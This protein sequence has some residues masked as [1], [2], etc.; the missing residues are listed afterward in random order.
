MPRSDS[1]SVIPLPTL[2]RI[3][4]YAGLI[5]FVIP[6]WLLLDQ[7]W[8]GLELQGAVPFGIYAPYIFISYS[9]V[10]L[11][12][13]SGT[14]WAS[15]QMVDNKNLAKFAVL[16][17]N[18][19]ALNA[20]CALLLIYIAPIMAAYSVTFLMFG[21]ISLLWVEHLIGGLEKVYWRMRLSL[22]GIVIIL[23]LVMITLI[24]MEL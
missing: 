16:I 15:W 5:P 17:S 18:L 10:I 13:M 4:G 11:S 6:V 9:A 24:F 20:W 2:I 7:L 1:T 19:F 23:H 8:F 3:L 21:F 14:L 22:T 12:F